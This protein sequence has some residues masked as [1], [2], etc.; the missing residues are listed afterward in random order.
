[1]PEQERHHTMLV[2]HPEQILP[3]QSPSKQ[4]SDLSGCFGVFAGAGTTDKQLC[5]GMPGCRCN[6]RRLQASQ[7]R[8]LSRRRSMREGS[9]AQK[10]ARPAARRPG[11]RNCVLLA[12]SRMKLQRRLPPVSSTYLPLR[13]RRGF[14]ARFTGPQYMLLLETWIGQSVTAL[15]R[16]PRTWHPT[17]RT[18][19][20]RQNAHETK[21]VGPA[22]RILTCEHPDV[23]YPN[24]ASVER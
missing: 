19:W 2:C 7:L 1:M 21:M 23:H 12:S 16:D 10:L 5:F 3:L 22:Q 17:F 8:P 14:G 18:A 11:R 15:P 6:E 4:C 9:R 24:L 13:G 20:R